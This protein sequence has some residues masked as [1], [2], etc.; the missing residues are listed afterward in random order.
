MMQCRN[1]RPNPLTETH[2][3][4]DRNNILP[5]IASLVPLASSFWNSPAAGS[6]HLDP[7]Y[8]KQNKF[9]FHKHQESTKN[10]C[11]ENLNRLKWRI[12]T[13]WCQY[14]LHNPD[15][16]HP[17][18]H[19]NQNGRTLPREQDTRQPQSHQSQP[20]Q[21][22]AKRTCH[23]PISNHDTASNPRKNYTANTAPKC[24]FKV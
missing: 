13:V 3:S 2:K 24:K 6:K 21:Y 14:L 1:H 15:C 22:S 12:Y 5:G 20:S 23:I 16:R 17:C 18:R 19:P 9:F 8:Q 10:W 7:H 4:N 11:S